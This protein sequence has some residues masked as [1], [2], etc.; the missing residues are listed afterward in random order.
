MAPPMTWGGG[1]TQESIQKSQLGLDRPM[2]PGLAPVSQPPTTPSQSFSGSAWHS[3]GS[4][5]HCDSPPGERPQVC[6]WPSGPGGPYPQETCHFGRDR[7]SRCKDSGSSWD[8]NPAVLGPVSL[9]A[10][11]QI[12]SY[13]GEAGRLGGGGGVRIRSLNHIRWPA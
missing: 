1:T 6:S 12:H 10:G 7:L 5:D 9:S 13:P 2:S 3:P 4:S 11:L 8:Q